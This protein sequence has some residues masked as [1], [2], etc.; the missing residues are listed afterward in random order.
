MADANVTTTSSAGAERRA[1]VA[2][3]EGLG[4]KQ[5][6]AY[7]AVVRT[8]RMLETVGKEHDAQVK[9]V[10]SGR[11]KTASTHARKTALMAEAGCRH[12][13]RCDCK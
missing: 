11:S 12:S 3:L 4:D 5:A 7:T 2:E 8:K 9:R 10:R 1:V 13:F 6:T